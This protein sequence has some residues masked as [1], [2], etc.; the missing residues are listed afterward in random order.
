MP[1]SAALAIGVAGLVAGTIDIAQALILFGWRVP[2]AITTA[3]VGEPAVRAGPT[4]VLY[5]LGLMLHYGIATTWATVFYLVSRRLPFMTEHWVVSGALFGLVVE[6]C[7]SYVVLPLSA[8]HATGP[9]ALRDILVGL[10]VHMITVGLPIA[11]VMR[12]YRSTP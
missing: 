5:A 2:L 1:K 10:I 4:A 12:R 3:L 8:L 9:Y 11:Y 7:M 6:L